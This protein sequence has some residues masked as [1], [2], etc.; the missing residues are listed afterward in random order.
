VGIIKSGGVFKDTPSSSVLLEL[1]SSKER[2]GNH[3]NQIKMTK[4]SQQ[5][6]EELFVVYYEQCPTAR[7]DYAIY[8]PTKTQGHIVLLDEWM[9]IIHFA[10]YQGGYSIKFTIVREDEC[11]FFDKYVDAVKYSSMPIDEFNEYVLSITL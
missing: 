2:N 11:Y 3:F 1:M 7:I 8:D 6:M 5:I 10:D 9:E 4:D